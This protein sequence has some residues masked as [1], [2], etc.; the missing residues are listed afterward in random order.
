MR[1]VLAVAIWLLVAVVHTPGSAQAVVFS[2]FPDFL[3]RDAQESATLLLTGLALLSL[4][5]LR[6]RPR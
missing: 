1:R 4:P 6:S 3:S 2:F 5:A